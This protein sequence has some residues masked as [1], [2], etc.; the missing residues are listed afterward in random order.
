MALRA[1]HVQAEENLRGLGGRLH[2]PLF[3]FAAEEVGG[4]VEVLDAFLVGV[5]A[6]RRDELLH[7]AVVGSVL[8][9]FAAQPLPHAGPAYRF[10]FGVAADEDCRP[11][12]GPVPRILVC[13]VVAEEPRY[14]IRLL[15]RR[16]VVEELLQF[17][18]GRDAADRVEKDA[19]APFAIG[20]I[21]RGLEL[22]V[23][24]SGRHL[25]VDEPD[26]RD[27]VRVVS[28]CCEGSAYQDGDGRQ[29]RDSP[30][31]RHSH[32]DASLATPMRLA[33][34]TKR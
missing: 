13:V 32:D 25:L 23:G 17:L 21:L 6:F 3:Q 22:R 4:A 8:L 27:A 14:E 5:R 7:E 24:P 19:T 34:R 28:C 31:T 18:D 16:S 2:A 29:A 12:V 11:D 26:L 30:R 33:H 15:G 9:E 1:L 10:I 20:G